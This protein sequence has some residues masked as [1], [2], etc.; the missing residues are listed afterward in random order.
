MEINK[1]FLDDCMKFVV[2]DPIFSPKEY[3][4]ILEVLGNFTIFENIPSFVNEFISRIVGME[5]QKMKVRVLPE[6]NRSDNYV[7]NRSNLGTNSVKARMS[8]LQ[9]NKIE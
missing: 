8:T 4:K 2:S 7:H 1:P 6:T 3:M 5:K 9:C